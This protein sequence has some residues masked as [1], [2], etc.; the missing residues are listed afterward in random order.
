M[1]LAPIVRSAA[2]DAAGAMITAERVRSTVA[3]H[4]FDIAAGT[5]I[6]VSI[7]VASYP[8]DG[9]ERGPLLEAADRAMYAAKR[10]GRN[11]VF[12]AADPIVEALLGGEGTAGEM[13]ERA[14]M[15]AVDALALLV[16]A[17]DRGDG[18]H[19]SRVARL[20][21]R[22]ALTLGC[23]PRQARD[24]YLAAKLHDI[25][26]VA[27]ADSILRK[28]GKLTEEEWEQLRRHPAT[29]AEVL[30]RIA[31]LANLA[32]IVRSHHEH[33]DGSGY[34]EGLKGEQIPLEARIVGAVDAVDAMLSDRPY[35]RRMSVEEAREELR[36]CAG[37]Q[38][39]PAV[40][41][42]LEGLLVE[43]RATRAA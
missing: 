28:P 36:R 25:G 19:I 16:D 24:V 9:R 33:F 6:T 30:S 27:I 14:T 4:A 15:G 34:P 29:G 2:V 13:D 41:K 7:G 37:T 12:S 23:S 22:T 1:R 43:D 11:Q 42:A 32:P 8:R 3:E 17:R 5:H 21:E 20:A 31:R 39:D 38:F 40:A 18:N 35:R 26:K 10:M